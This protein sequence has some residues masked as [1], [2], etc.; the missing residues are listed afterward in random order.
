MHSESLHPH[1]NLGKPNL[2]R[3][4]MPSVNVHLQVYMPDVCWQHT[5]Y[6]KRESRIVIL[7]WVLHI[8]KNNL[9]RLWL[10]CYLNSLNSYIKKKTKS[11]PCH[12]QFICLFEGSPFY[13]CVS[14]SKWEVIVPLICHSDMKPFPHEWGIAV[15]SQHA[16]HCLC[17]S[18]L[19]FSLGCCKD[20]CCTPLLQWVSLWSRGRQDAVPTGA[21]G[22]RVGT[23]QLWCA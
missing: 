8:D 19:P 6:Q 13:R 10:V 7:S 4:F 20:E 12:I 14:N 22:G 9:C 2:L 23:Y 16:L 5:C 3:Y 21:A 11:T 1:L 18:K 17:V 15:V